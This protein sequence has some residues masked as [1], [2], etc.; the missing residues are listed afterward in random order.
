MMSEVIVSEVIV[1]NDE[2]PPYFKGPPKW[3]I[4]IVS[5]VIVSEVIVSEVMMSEVIVSEVIVINDDGPPYF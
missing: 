1:I 3:V 2:G 5:E 4:V